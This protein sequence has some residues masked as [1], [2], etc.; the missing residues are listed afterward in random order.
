MTF[1]NCPICT[2][3][4]EPE[5]THCDCCD[6]LLNPNT[7]IEDNPLENEFMTLTGEPRSKAKLY[8]GT[9]I[10]NNSVDSA[11]AL[12]YEDKERENTNIDNGADQMVSN[13]L[14]L[15]M[16]SYGA[17]FEAPKTIKDLLCQTLYRRGRNE[18]H[19]CELCDSRAFLIISKILSFKD[20]NSNIIRM[21]NHE[22]LVSLNVTSDRYEE[23]VK[24]IFENINNIFLPAILDNLTKYFNDAYYNRDRLQNEGSSLEI[25]EEVMNARNGLDFRIIWDILHQNTDKVDSEKIREELSTLLNSEEFH[26][27]LNQSWESPVYNHPAS[28]EDIDS[29][30]TVILTKE[31]LELEHLKDDKCSICMENFLPDGRSVTMLGCHSFCTKC[32]GEWLGNHNDCC[33]VCRKSIS[34]CNQNKKEDNV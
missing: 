4:N 16:S 14:N 32:I 25:I 20:S 17:S 33:P 9:E 27:Y 19:Y 5:N 22:D 3:L 13:L 21:F 18:P 2:Y 29:L 15:L 6:S 8:L 34:T 31:S 10:A 23:V 24:E 7:E 28:K 11:V 12:Y 30:K 1:I 26:S